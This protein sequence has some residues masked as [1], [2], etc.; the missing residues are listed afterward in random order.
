MVESND[1]R[2]VPLLPVGHRNME[3]PWLQ[4]A[5]TRRRLAP[6][7]SSSCELIPVG[8]REPRPQPVEDRTETGR[9]HKTLTTVESGPLGSV[10]IPAF[11]EANVV[12]R[13]LNSLFD[14][15]DPADL[16]VVV[17][18]N[19]C[20]DGTVGVAKEVKAPVTV[21][22]LPAV[23]KAG[24]I[25]AAELEV[26]TLPRLYLDADV[27]LEGKSAVAVLTAL[28]DGA[29]A[30][31]PPLRY[32]TTG[33]SWLVKR[34]YGQRMRLPGV[35]ADLCGAGVYGLSAAARARFQDFPDVIA[36]DLFAARVVEPS[37]VTIVPCAPVLVSVPRN[38]RSLV[39]TLARARRGNR[40]LFDR[41]PAVAR[42]TTT[43]TVRHLV[44]SMTVPARFVDA[45]VYAAIV[46]LGRLLA[47]RR[48]SSWGRDESS[49]SA[50]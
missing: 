37:E 50:T 27:R 22:D 39:R 14:G 31:R 26:D 46:T 44:R 33:A 7:N 3:L 34:Y 48:T 43:S 5:R 18:C 10:V 28:R 6:L 11:N 49:R 30:A 17:A 45:A 32:D 20:T 40:E 13:T 41:M 16:E 38:V 12:E 24:A 19:G 23:G 35:H 15:V 29:V 9:P 2:H 42:S 1:R 36:D 21:L 47:T 8:R 25:R 4:R